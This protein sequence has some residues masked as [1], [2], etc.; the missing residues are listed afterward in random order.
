MYHRDMKEEVD[1]LRDLWRDETL[2]TR[3]FEAHMR[4]DVS[5]ILREAL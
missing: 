1:R 4:G 5:A 3:L 2:V